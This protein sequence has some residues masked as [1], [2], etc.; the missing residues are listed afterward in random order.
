MDESSWVTVIIFVV[1]LAV[2]GSSLWAAVS[3]TIGRLE[4]KIEGITE[5]CHD[6]GAQHDKHFT[7]AD[8][9]NKTLE[10][11]SVRITQVEGRVGALESWRMKEEA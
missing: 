4:T 3:K 9:A 1:G 11:H 2:Q 10:N 6:R 7:N 8:H 5:R